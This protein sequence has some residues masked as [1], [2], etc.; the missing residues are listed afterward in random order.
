MA[1]I[2]RDRVPDST[3]ALVRDGYRFISRRCDQ[4]GADAFLTRL[5]LRPTFCLR[6]AAAARWF[7]DESRVLRQGAAPGRMRKTLLGTGGVQGLDGPAHRHRKQML[8][9]IMTPAAID[10]LTRRCDDGW[11]DHAR[12]WQ[13]RQR[14]VLHDEAG[15]CCAG[16]SATG[17]ACHCRKPT[18]RGAPTSSA[19]SSRDPARSARRIGAPCWPA[20]GSST[21]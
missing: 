14:V 16:P 10:E 20:A 6:G 1:R 15:G 3:L 5:L 12:Q 4:Y 18:C 7:Y 8:M 17:P 2:P 21:G 19:P 13:H 11:R 9:S